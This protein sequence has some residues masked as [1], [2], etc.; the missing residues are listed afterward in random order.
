MRRLT[1]FPLLACLIFSLAASATSSRQP[2]SKTLRIA[3]SE[4]RPYVQNDPNYFGYAYETVSAAFKAA[5]YHIAVQFMTW[6][7]VQEAI[8]QG[9]IDGVFPSY[10]ARNRHRLAYSEPFSGGPLGLLHLK[11]NRLKVTFNKMAY[12]PWE[13]FRDLSNY[14]FGVVRYYSYLPAFDDNSALSKYVVLTDQ[15]NLTQLI[16]GKVDIILMD[17]YVARYYLHNHFNSV[18]DKVEFIDPALAYKKLYFAVPRNHPQRKAI[19]SAFNYGLTTIHRNGEL[20][21]ILAEDAKK[22]G[23]LL[24]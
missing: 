3:T 14:R 2:E 7:E 23:Q 5:G 20:S 8:K 6:A 9:T 24:S 4:W 1:L 10:K 11:K 21:H 12:D 16:E 19:L 22:M 13:L 18:A 17:K 15:Q